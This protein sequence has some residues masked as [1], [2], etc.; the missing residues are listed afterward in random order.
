ML[1]VELFLF[2]GA[3]KKEST[4]I[5]CH[6]VPPTNSF[7]FIFNSYWILKSV[8]DFPSLP[9]LSVFK[10]WGGFDCKIVVGVCLNLIIF[11][12]TFGFLV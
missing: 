6:I 1:F 12:D 4:F 3:F 8:Q 10:I 5:C 2:S 9:L 11:V 7:F